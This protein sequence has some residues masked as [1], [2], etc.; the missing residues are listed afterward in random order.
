MLCLHRVYTKTY[1]FV[2][3]FFDAVAGQTPAR[4]AF[5]RRTNAYIFTLSCRTAR[6]SDSQIYRFG[7][8]VI[9]NYIFPIVNDVYSFPAITLPDG[10][11][12]P[13]ARGCISTP[14]KRML[15]CTSTPLHVVSAQSDDG[16]SHAYLQGTMG[17]CAKTQ[18]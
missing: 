16:N 4:Q 2:N 11:H 17:D 18:S 12:L 6:T 3:L 10:L 9:F 5:F 7:I 13:G 8:W 1:K 14:D 15:I